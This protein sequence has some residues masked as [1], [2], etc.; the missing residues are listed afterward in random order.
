VPSDAKFGLVVGVVLVIAIAVIFFRKEVP[1]AD[2]RIVGEIRAEPRA[3]LTAAP[4]HFVRH[5]VRDGDTLFSLARQYYQDDR[6][7]VD[8][9]QA[10]RDTVPSPTRLTP[11]TVLVIPDAA[12]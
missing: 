8:I 9:F 2:P 4:G 3:P 10:N 1:P 7:F 6:R 11:G 5:T 12:P